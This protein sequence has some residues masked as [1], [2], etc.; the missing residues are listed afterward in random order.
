[1]V[2][3]KNQQIQVKGKKLNKEVNINHSTAARQISLQI[4][5]FPAGINQQRAV[6]AVLI[7]VSWGSSFM[8]LLK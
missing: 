6:R 2:V 5:N 8:L 4:P 1:M 3:E 7:Y